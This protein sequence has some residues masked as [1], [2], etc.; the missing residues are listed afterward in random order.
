MKEWEKNKR[1]GIEWPH[2]RKKNENWELNETTKNQRVRE[3][4]NKAKNYAYGITKR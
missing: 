2:E 1:Y 4:E 3:K